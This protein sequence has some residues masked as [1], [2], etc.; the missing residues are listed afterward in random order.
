M[1]L[2]LPVPVR[3]A[4]RRLR[5][6]APR[7]VVVGIGIAV[8][9]AALAMTAVGSTAVRDRAVQRALAQLPPSERAIQATW[10]GVPGQSN[11]SLPQLDRTARRALRP[12]LRQP[13]FA[14]VVFRQAS[15]GGAFVNL[16]AVDGLARW[17]V[18]RNGRLPRSCLPHDCELVQIGGAAVAP[19]LPFLHVV[20]R[21]SFRSGAPL[22]AYFGGGGRRPPILLAEGVVA[23]SRTPLPDGDLIARSYGWIVPV[24]PGSIHDWELPALGKRLDRAQS[25]L[26][27]ASDLFGV[28]A[29]TDTIA[30][31]RATSRV[32]GERLLILGGD[33]SALLLGFAVLAS[34]RL[35]RDQRAVRRRLTWFGANRSQILLVAATEVAGI[36]LVS[37][38]LGWAAGTGAGA[39]LARHLGAPGGLVVAHS[40]FTVPAFAAAAALALGT[41]LVLLAA[42]QTEGIAFGGLKLSVAD[43]AALGA[44]GAILLALAR[45]K[46][47]AAA[48]AAGGG[49]GV[50][51][52]LLPGLVLF[53]LAVTAARLL[54]PALRL[55]E[56]AG[57]RGPAAVRVSLLSL[58]RSPGQ[59]LLSVVFFVLSIGVALFAIAYRATLERGETEQ[60]RY[61][62]PA[63]FVLQED[64]QQLVPVQQAV[65]GKLAG[66][67][68]TATPVL[69]DAGFV[70]A[71]SG[72]DFTLVALPARS[73]AGI[74]GW[75]ADFS[76]QTPAALARLLQPPVTPALRGPTL[77]QGARTL[78]LPLTVSGETVGVAVVVLDRR[79][80][81][82]V[83]QLGE[84]GPGRHVRTVTVPTAARGGR[85]VALRLSFPVIAAFVAGH[86]ESGTA[87]SVADA[88]TGVLRIGRLRAGKIAL[89]SFA[90]WIGTGGVRADGST[91]R[92]LVNR[93]ADSFLRPHE[94]L[95]G[96]PVPVV[97]SPA[98]ART[99]GPDGSVTLH[100]AEQTIAARVVAVSHYFPSA[101]GDFVAADLPTWLAAVNTAEPGT[102]VPGEIWLDAPPSAAARLARPPFDALQLSSQ[103]AAAA[104]L[105]ADPLARGALTLLLATAIVGL[106]LA[107]VGLLLVVIGDL[108]DGGGELFDLQAQGATP[109]DLQRH[110]F[111]RA[112]VVAVLGLAAG[113]AAGAIVSTLVVAVVTV[114]AGAGNAVPPLA[115]VYDWRFV[116]VALVAVA[117]SSIVGASAVTRLAYD[118]VAR[119]RFSEGIE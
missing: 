82:S 12:V 33:A 11:L 80:D 9:T 37:S 46:A 27:Q 22:G 92:Y 81:F 36:T 66:S 35:R 110:L 56:W 75:R 40:A 100:V 91:V 115:L 3:F 31:V 88:S 78:T 84:L 55:L 63:P 113:V 42:L 117:A 76:P 4:V 65:P 2:V 68:G 69:R 26:E 32:A 93:A 95:E 47:D 20:G 86:R 67:L 107:A 79:G 17:L 74:D 28:S 94:P 21:A 57:R 116:V 73:L 24:A 44:L 106:V 70:S 71:G 62:V 58:A 64:L 119:V 61:S 104:D 6:H 50:V 105:R 98:I 48:L 99:A 111:L 38:V 77:P 59:V 52:L 1:S 41:A 51:L 60:A 101:Y 87:L 90:G 118:R 34:T 112:A 96:L 72:R 25:R 97:A 83:L 109:A 45:G 30:A 7:T 114:T 102:A 23:F 29:P 103:R 53:V 10:S 39:L 16:G 19:R 43:A 89:P 13:P 54:A 8:S 49:I 5:A 15:W 108:R 85:V 18:L 14:V